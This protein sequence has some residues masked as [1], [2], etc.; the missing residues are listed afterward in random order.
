MC[1]WKTQERISSYWSTRVLTQLP[2]VILCYVVLEAALDW[3][4]S[5]YLTVLWDHKI[6][7]Y[8]I[9]KDN[10]AEDDKIIIIII[11]KKYL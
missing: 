6:L 2:Q 7:K 9:N 3:Q 11:M 4:I 1:S 10:N 8:S 5:N